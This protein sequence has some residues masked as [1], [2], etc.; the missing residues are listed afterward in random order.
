[1]HVQND[2]QSGLSM[3]QYNK[4]DKKCYSISLHMIATFCSGFDGRGIL[5]IVFFDKSLKYE[6][7]YIII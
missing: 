2:K 5:I 4:Q 7:I 3:A 1:M 6:Y